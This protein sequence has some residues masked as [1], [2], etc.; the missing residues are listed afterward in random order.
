MNCKSTCLSQYFWGFQVHWQFHEVGYLQFWISVLYNNIWK[1][2]NISDFHMVIILWSI[3]IMEFHENFSI[4]SIWKA[5]FIKWKPIRLS[6]CI[7]DSFHMFIDGQTICVLQSL[8]CEYRS[9][10]KYPYTSLW[11]CTASAFQQWT[12]GYMLQGRQTLYPSS[13]LN[14]W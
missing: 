7:S 14:L 3:L 8:G 4:C 1:C 13:K 10:V 6:V 5:A 11:G 9:N 2:L 12:H